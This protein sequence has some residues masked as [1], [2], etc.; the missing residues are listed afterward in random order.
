[1]NIRF[2]TVLLAC[3]L[4]LAS[5]AQSPAGNPTKTNAAPAAEARTPRPTITIVNLNTAD[6]ATLARDMDGI[7]ESKA[8]AI[9]EHRQRNGGFRSVDELALVKGIGA[10][11]LD[12]NRARLTVGSGARA[13]A[14]AKSVPAKTTSA[15]SR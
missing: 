15:T 4:P 3:L 8:R 1:M 10:K 14:V 7:G 2:I 6:A 5:S 11:T 13:P 12:R 9:V